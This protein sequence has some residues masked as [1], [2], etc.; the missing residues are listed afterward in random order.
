VRHGSKLAVRHLPERGAPAPPAR[1]RGAIGALRDASSLLVRATSPDA[2]HRA[3][4]RSEAAQRWPRC[5]RRDTGRRR[6][7]PPLRMRRGPLR[8]SR[9]GRHRD[10]ESTAARQLA[11]RDSMSGSVRVTQ[12][13]WARAVRPKHWS[14]ATSRPTG[15]AGQQRLAQARRVVSS[16]R[17]QRHRHGGTGEPSLDGHDGTAAIESPMKGAPD[18]HPNQNPG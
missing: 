17:A 6:R 15:L 7:E 2:S 13:A 8:P 3:P 5:R 11:R 4:R 14:E 18:G 12:P 10:L 1:S 16:Q 9:A